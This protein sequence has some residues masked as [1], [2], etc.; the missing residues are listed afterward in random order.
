MFVLLRGGNSLRSTSP[1]IVYRTEYVAS[2]LFQTLMLQPS[3]TPT[4]KAISG[5]AIP[6]MT[7]D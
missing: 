3:G 4:L 7:S 2:E 5:P 6:I 1:L